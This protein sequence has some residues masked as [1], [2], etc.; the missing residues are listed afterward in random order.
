MKNKILQLLQMKPST[1][2]RM[3]FNHY[4][5]WCAYQAFDSKDVQKLLT[6]PALFNWYAD[7]YVKMEAC[8]AHRAAEFHGKVDKGVM[9]DLHTEY[10]INTQD[11][12]STPLLRKARA[13][14]PIE[15]Q[16]N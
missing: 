3:L 2:E 11:F 1:Y 16:L 12:Y 14:K 10:V 6:C 5:K 7:M 8:F 4:H 15:P 13:Q 9:L